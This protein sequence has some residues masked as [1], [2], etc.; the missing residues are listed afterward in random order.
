[1]QNYLHFCYANPTLYEKRFP[2]QPFFI[3]GH[4]YPIVERLFLLKIE[5]Y[6]HI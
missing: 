3:V 5:I 6:F 2:K 4:S 1:M